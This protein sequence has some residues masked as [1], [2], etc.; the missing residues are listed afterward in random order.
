M[1]GRRTGFVLLEQRIRRQPDGRA[2]RRHPPHRL[3]SAVHE[4]E[5]T[6]EPVSAGVTDGR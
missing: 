2:H 4:L 6:L 1:P 5:N 3:P